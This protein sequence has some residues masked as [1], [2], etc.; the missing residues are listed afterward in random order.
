[1]PTLRQILLKGL[2][3][4]TSLISVL[5]LYKGI[6][7]LANTQSPLVVVLSGSM[8]PAFHRGDILFLT[9][10]RTIQY[11]TGDIV[12]YSVPGAEIPIVHRVMQALDIEREYDDARYPLDGDVKWFVQPQYKTWQAESEGDARDQLLL[13]KGDNNDVDDIELYNG[14]DGLQRKHIIGKVRWF[15]PYVG[16]ASIIMNEM[17]LVKYGFFAILGL[18]SIL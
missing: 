7:V 3:F 10:P 5:V 4:L 16:Y 8:A 15:L 12:V 17:P 9:N 18:V 14:L 11:K 2:S 13:T 6:G 1:M